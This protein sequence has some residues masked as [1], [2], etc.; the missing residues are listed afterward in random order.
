MKIK[1]LIIITFLLQVFCI[2]GQNIKISSNFPAGNIVIN[3]IEKDTVWLKRILLTQLS[4]YQPKASYFLTF[5]AT[6][7]Q[8][9]LTINCL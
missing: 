9:L 6:N 8:F 1:I 3:K 5:V 7:I 4:V 2:T